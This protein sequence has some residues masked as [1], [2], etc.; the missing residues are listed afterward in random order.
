VHRQ[1][2]GH[3]LPSER[4]LL[5]LRSSAV[6]LIRE[7]ELRCAERPWIFARTLIPPKTL[8]RS[9]RRLAQLR[10]RPLGA[11]LFADPGVQRK[12]IEVARLT[13]RHQLFLWAIA[14]T[15]PT[16]TALW[17]RRAVFYRMG[18]PLLVHE[19]FLPEI[20]L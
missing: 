14:S 11:V 3:P 2:W 7:V 20:P 17:A 16:T 1:F 6:V 19:V 15:R 9:G 10:E 18:N 8:R 12:P 4:R 5:R 13:S